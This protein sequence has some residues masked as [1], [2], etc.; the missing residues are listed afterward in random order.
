VAESVRSYLDLTL[1]NPDWS[2]LVVWR[3]LGDSSEG[4]QDSSDSSTDSTPD[5]PSTPQPERL[6]A[7]VE[8]M[9][10]R[11]AAGE[12]ADDLDPAFALLLCYALTFAPI[13]L[14]Q[15]VRDITGT[16]PLSPEYRDRC[17]AEIVKLLAP[18]SLAPD[19]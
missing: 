10:E 17:T 7:A 2:R 8:R 1:D 4:P 11:Q 6:R 12:I 18:R 13:A 19:A 14:P 5:S 3:A 15:F 16:D 9:R